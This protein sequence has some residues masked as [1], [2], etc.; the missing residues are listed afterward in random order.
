MNT[1]EVIKNIRT[2]NNKTQQEFADSISVSRSTVSQIESGKANPTMEILDNIVNVYNIDANLL[3]NKNSKLHSKNE[4][5]LKDEMGNEVNLPINI[6]FLN[7]SFDKDLEKNYRRLSTLKNQIL[8]ICTFLK[9]KTQYQ[10]DKKE[11]EMLTLIE[12]FLNDESNGILRL[13]DNG[14]IEYNNALKRYILASEEY[15]TSLIDYLK[16]EIKKPLKNFAEL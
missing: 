7:D 12:D 6:D 5:L 3:F 4:T 10:F 8:T 1:G 15:L 9:E 11:V 2:T 14:R 16:Y 13:M